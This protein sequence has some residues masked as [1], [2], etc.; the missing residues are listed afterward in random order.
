MMSVVDFFDDCVD[1]GNFWYVFS[2]GDLI[3]IGIYL[4]ELF[5]EYY[6]VSWL[7]CVGLYVFL[8]FVMYI[9]FKWLF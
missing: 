5:W 7:V 2:F 1:V 6:E 9:D 8:M 4:I 3:G